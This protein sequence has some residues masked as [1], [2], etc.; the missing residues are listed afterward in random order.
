MAE[1]DA[2]RLEAGHQV[3]EPAN[4]GSRRRRR[5]GWK[6]LLI[7]VVVWCTIWGRLDPLTILGGVLVSFLIV[8]L[9]PLPVI[10]FKGKVRPWGL[11]KLVV[12]TLYDLVK[13][14]IWVAGL[15]L[16]LRKT[17]RSAIVTVDLRTSSDLLIAMI[18]ELVGLVPGSVVIQVD[19][20]TSTLHVHILDVDSVDEL[21]EAYEG[22]RI[23]ERR[24]IRAF[25]SDEELAAIAGEPRADEGEVA[26]GRR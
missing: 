24:V 3:M 13:S 16:N 26:H 1:M 23:V 18:V 15:A 22:V 8:V 21:P 12:L 19:R 4:R 6:S 17:V 20:A 14:S 11:A 2:D 10:R 5:I 7:G 9:F 25:G